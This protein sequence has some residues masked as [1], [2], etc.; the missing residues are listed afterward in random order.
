MAEIENLTKFINNLNIDGNE[1]EMLEE[2]EED[3]DNDIRI[4]KEIMKYTDEYQFVNLLRV[5]IKIIENN[6][7]FNAE[8]V[9]N[10]VILNN[11]L[12]GIN[13]QFSEGNLPFKA[14]IR[15]PAFNKQKHSSPQLRYQY[16]VPRD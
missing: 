7:A 13:T 4:E 6:P 2:N 10:V 3:S 5:I 1:D 8:I 14:L 16:T 9:D 11:I 12:Y 15:L